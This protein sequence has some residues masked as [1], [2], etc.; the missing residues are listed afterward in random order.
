LDY[1]K[2]LSHGEYMTKYEDIIKIDF[3]GTSCG[4][5]FGSKHDLVR[6]DVGTR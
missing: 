5:P 3:K 4:M 2:T 1:S 6:E